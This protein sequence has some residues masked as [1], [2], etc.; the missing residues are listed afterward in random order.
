MACDNS[1]RLGTYRNVCTTMHGQLVCTAQRTV[2]RGRAF[3]L[4][5]EF[6]AVA[7]PNFAD[8]RLVCVEAV[9]CVITT[10]RLTAAYLHT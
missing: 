7:R 3:D 2:G 5:Q 4:C 10:G 9:W 6:V 1:S 8:P